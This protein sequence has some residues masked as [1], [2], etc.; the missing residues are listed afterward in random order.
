M[1]DIDGARLADPAVVEAVGDVQLP[2]ASG[3]S[4]DFGFESVTAAVKN[5]A[6]RVVQQIRTRRRPWPPCCSCSHELSSS[7]RRRE[8][9]RGS[10]PSLVFSLRYFEG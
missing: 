8:R 5:H 4:L 7:R 10:S 1:D 2:R 6:K 3:R 9:S